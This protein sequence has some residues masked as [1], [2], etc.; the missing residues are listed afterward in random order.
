MGQ[1]PIGHGRVYTQQRIR[2]IM[3]TMVKILSL[4]V[5]HGGLLVAVYSEPYSEVLFNPESGLAQTLR[6]M[7]G[8]PQQRCDCFSSGNGIDFSS[9]GERRDGI[10]LGS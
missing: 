6:A 1:L 8:T 9:L 10:I 7:S 5:V 2:G 4:Q 3:S